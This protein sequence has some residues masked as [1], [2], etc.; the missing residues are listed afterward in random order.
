[1]VTENTVEAIYV[2]LKAIL[3]HLLQMVIEESLE[4]LNSSN[5]GGNLHA[6]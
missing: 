6:E 3:M 4:H 5:T 1:M 2:Q